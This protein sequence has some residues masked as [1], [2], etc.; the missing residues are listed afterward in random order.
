MKNTS[1]WMAV[2]TLTAVILAAILLGN[3][4][5]QAQAAMIN[6]QPGFILMTTGANGGDEGLV[7]IDKT[8]LKMVIYAFKGN[9]LIPLARTSL[10]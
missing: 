6:A 10:R 8:Q 9:D 1:I 7:V 2:L 4:D 5:R 3:N